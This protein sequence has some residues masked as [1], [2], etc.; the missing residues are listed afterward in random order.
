MTEIGEDE[1]VDT[2]FALM[3]PALFDRLTRQRDWTL[4]QL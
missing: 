2:L 1:A 3:E 4:A